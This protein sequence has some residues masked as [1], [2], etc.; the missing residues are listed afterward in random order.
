M[1]WARREDLDQGGETLVHSEWRDGDAPAK[2]MAE[3]V[4][5]LARSFAL[6]SGA[7]RLPLDLDMP[8]DLAERLRETLSAHEALLPSPDTEFIRLG[9]ADTVALDAA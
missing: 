9:G 1:C 7:K 8:D 2:T 4:A 3:K 6:S 5:R